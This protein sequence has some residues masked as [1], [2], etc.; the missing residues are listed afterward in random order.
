MSNNDTA[1]VGS[2]S[3]ASDSPIRDEA[4]SP[5]DSFIV[6]A[7]A[8]SGKTA[9]LVRRYLNL[10]TVVRQPEEILAITFTDKAAREMKSRVLKELA[11]QDGIAARVHERSNRLHWDLELYPQ[12]MKIQ[13]IDSFAYSIVQRMPIE[14]QLSLDY[15]SMEKSDEIY[16]EAAI[17]FFEQVLRRGS[18]TQYA[19]DIL[20]L[21][22]NNIDHAI[23]T[24]ANMLSH[25]QNWIKSV[26]RVLLAK[27]A[28]ESEAKIFAQLEATRNSYVNN[29]IETTRRSI[30]RAF[31]ER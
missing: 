18:N 4:V 30:P 12:R 15:Q 14:C 27:R 28:G 21:F 31:L 16:F 11:L 17:E 29:V 13:T 8:G 19:T 9:L 26:Q 1:L 2:V 22:E 24:L 6:Q 7:P 20:A 23:D 5:T 10:L 25:R 3:L